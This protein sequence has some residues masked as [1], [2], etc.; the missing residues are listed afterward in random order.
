MPLLRYFVYVGG[1][2]LALILIINWYL[3]PTNAESGGDSVD[4]SIIRIH[5]VQKWPAAVVFDTTQPT[6]VPPPAIAAA[7][8]AIEPTAKLPRE[9]LAM[10]TEPA[11]AIA[12]TVKAA[13]A[14]KPAKPRVRRTRVARAPS[15]SHVASYDAF[16]FRN[17]FFGS[18]G[19]WQSGW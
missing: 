1:A 12:P 18:R 14:V 2:L 3:P 17:E 7:A 15:G 8:A 6:I 19:M 4:R 5:S 13:E 10:A 11:P 9:A 16:G